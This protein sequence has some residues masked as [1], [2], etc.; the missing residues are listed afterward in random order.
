MGMA[1]HIK[2]KHG[3]KAAEARKIAVQVPEIEH[4]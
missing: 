4:G 1:D 2:T 3:L